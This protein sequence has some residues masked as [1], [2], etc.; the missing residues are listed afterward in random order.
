MISER[1]FEPVGEEAFEKARTVM[2]SCRQVICPLRHF[3]TMNKR[4]EALLTLARENNL[5]TE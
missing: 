3:G 2:L 1:A 5:L 4:N